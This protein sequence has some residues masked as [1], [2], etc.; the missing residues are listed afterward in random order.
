MCAAPGGKTTH[1]A[2]LMHDQGTVIALDKND[3]KAHTIRRLCKQLKLKC[4]SAIAANAAKALETVQAEEHGAASGTCAEG[5]SFRGFAAGSFDRVL[6]DAPCSGL[7]LR[8]RF[9]TELTLVH[10]D[11]MASYQRQRTCTTACHGSAL[12]SIDTCH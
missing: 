4:V 5:D 9:R 1:I 2:T 8:P 11:E 7:G 12:R 6:L 3:K 10:L